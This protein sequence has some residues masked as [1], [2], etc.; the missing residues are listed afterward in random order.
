[1][2]V[3]VCMYVRV[4]GCM[5]VCVCACVRTTL[6]TPLHKV[7]CQ[8]LPEKSIGM[9]WPNSADTAGS[10][11]G[12]AAGAAAMTRNEAGRMYDLHHIS[13]GT[14]AVSDARLDASS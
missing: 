10:A 4:R 3:C 1:M 6:R 2:R 8:S 11:A 9:R 13:M 5:C 7:P 14:S 12:A